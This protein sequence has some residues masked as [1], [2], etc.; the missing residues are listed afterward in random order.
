MIRGNRRLIITGA[1]GYIGRN[2]IPRLLKKGYKIT[3]LARNIEKKNIKWFKE[4][5]LIKLNFNKVSINYDQL[6]KNYTLIHLAW[7]GLP[8]YYSSVH[9]K[10]NVKQHFVFIKKLI[11]KKIVRNLVVTGSCQEY[12]MKLGL[13]KVNDETNPITSYGKAKVR[14][15]K[16]LFGLKK[17][18]NFNFQWLRLYYSYGKWQNKNSLF[19]QLD[20]SIKNNKKYFNMSKGDQK[21]DYLPISKIIIKIIK[22]LENKKEGIFN[23]CSGKPIKLKD[24]VQKF[25]KIKK[26]KIKLKLGCYPYLDYEPKYFWGDNNL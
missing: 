7:E 16:K 12:G 10:K 19:S 9:F 13:Q 8:N 1:T 23:V 4:V 2:L 20:L 25:I 24:L 18:Y 5:K 11:Q 14:L 22:A 17:K 3:I 6:K 26:S 21:I 15:Y